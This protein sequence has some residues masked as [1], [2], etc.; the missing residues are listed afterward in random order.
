MATTIGSIGLNNKVCNIV[1]FN[2][3]SKPVNLELSCRN[4]YIDFN[5]SFVF[6][7]VESNEQDC[8]FI[9]SRDLYKNATKLDSLSDTNC[10]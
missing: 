4:G 3:E 6:G 8:V 1:P 5:N 7:L 10:R 9:H 2:N